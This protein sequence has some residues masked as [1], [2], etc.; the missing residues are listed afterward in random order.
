MD[1]QTHLLGPALV[2][3][4]VPRIIVPGPWRLVQ[5]TLSV[6]IMEL[7]CDLGLLTLLLDPT[8]ALGYVW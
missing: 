8:L 4:Y 2:L 1:D 3:P 5:G 6:S 7:G